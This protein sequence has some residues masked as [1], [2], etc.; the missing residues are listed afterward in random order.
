M[1]I[2]A[3]P[4]APLRVSGSSP[5]RN[6]A[7]DSP[8]T[9]PESRGPREEPAFVALDDRTLRARLATRQV[10][11]EQFNLQPDINRQARRALETYLNVSRQADDAPF[12]ELVG[13]DITV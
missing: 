5:S 10:G 4:L 9:P 8:G 2:G 7:S 13:L 1:E 6:P 11:A 3:L 12:G